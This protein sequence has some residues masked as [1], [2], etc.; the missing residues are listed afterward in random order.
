MA[1]FSGGIK[2]NAL[3]KTPIAAEKKEMAGEDTD[4]G[5]K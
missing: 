1:I 2:T 4:H 3:V 5:K